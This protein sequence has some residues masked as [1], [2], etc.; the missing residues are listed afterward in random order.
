MRGGTRSMSEAPLT[1]AMIAEL[2]DSRLDSYVWRRLCSRVS[3]GSRDDIE[4]MH[5]LVRA[6]LVTRMFDWEVGNGGLRQYFLDGYTT[7]GLDDQRRV[8]EERIVPVAY[9]AK[10][11]RMRSRDRVDFFGPRRKKSQL[12]ELNDLIG[13]HDGER[14]ALIRA[15]PE[16]FAS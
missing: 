16:L 4:A 6:Y 5:P 11:R 10:E 14:I 15:N 13:E 2:P 7:L 8:I 1:A 3:M 12:D 9:S